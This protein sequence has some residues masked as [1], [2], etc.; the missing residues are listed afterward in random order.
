MRDKINYKE[1]LEFRRQQECKR[2]KGETRC[3]PLHKQK[4]IHN[5]IYKSKTGMKTRTE[6]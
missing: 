1:G 4:K 6:L 2:K 3:V 5:V